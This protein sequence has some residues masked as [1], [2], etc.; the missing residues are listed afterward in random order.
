MKRRIVSLLLALTMV[1]TLLPCPA[2][3]AEDTA[4]VI[5]AGTCGDCVEWALLNDGTLL[6]AGNGKIYDYADGSEAPWAGM[7]V[8][9]AI[10]SEGVS[11]IGENAFAV[12]ANMSLILFLDTAPAFS[13]GAFNGVTAAAVYIP[14]SS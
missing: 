4:E 1:L 8:T 3:A 13:T 12:C 6:I 7:S 14:G 9:S 11:Y 10:V 2:A 5:A